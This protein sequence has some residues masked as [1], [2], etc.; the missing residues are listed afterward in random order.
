MTK[1]ITRPSFSFDES[2][3]IVD[4]FA[5]GGGASTGIEMAVGRAPDIAINHDPEAIA[6]HRA[7]HPDTLHFISDVFELNPHNVAI[8]R[9]VGLLW[10]SPDCKHFSKA[11]G[12]KPKSKRIRSLAWV[13]VK[14]ARAK[15]P[16]IIILENVEEFQ[17][18]GPLKCDGTVCDLRRGKTF[19]LF[20]SSLE[21]LGYRVEWRELRACDYGAPTIRKRLFMIARR[22]G[23][24]IVWP[25]QTHG[26]P[27]SD[28]VRSG[29]IKPW[30]TV[31]ECIDFTLPTPSIFLSKEEGR[32]LGVRR[33]LSAKTMER[34]AKGV[35]RFVIDNHDPFIVPKANFISTYYGGR[36]GDAPMRGSGIDDPVATITAGGLRHAL[37]TAFMAQHNLGNVGRDLRD[38]MSTVTTRGSQQTLVTSHIMKMRNNNIGSPADE[39]IH[40]ITAGGLHHAEVR[41][42][43]TKYYGAGTGQ[44]LTDPAHTVTTKDR[45][46]LVTVHGEP[47]RIVDIG[48]RMLTPRELFNAQG[49]P[50]DYRID[51]EIDGKKITKTAQV[52]MCGN[53]VC[54]PLAAALVGANYKDAEIS[55]KN[56]RKRMAV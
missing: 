22:D 10:L 13:G 6:M 23:E 37:V 5:G 31:A 34:I 8:G 20:V 27:K 16:R 47:Y 32:R 44:D 54:P 2:E 26:D 1:R 50:D 40:S 35:K 41:A 46:G 12:G 4:L 33:P 17:E 29:R 39:P 9:P 42:F 38:P 14:W 7:N 56:N 43:L 52:R 53:S 49:F 36:G 48:M 45:M 51:I 30:R 15:R 28:S 21:R 19:R 25:E 3:I 24:P 55:G 11:K 18:W